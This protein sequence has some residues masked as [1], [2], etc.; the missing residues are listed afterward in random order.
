MFLDLNMKKLNYDIIET[1]VVHEKYVIVMKS[2]S[3]SGHVIGYTNIDAFCVEGELI[4]VISKFI[5]FLKDEDQG[6][7]EHSFDEKRFLEYTKILDPYTDGGYNAIYELH[8]VEYINKN[9]SRFIVSSPENI[10]NF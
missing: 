1:P 10:Y 5:E 8:R 7:F 9:G 6:Y 2:K 4:E 3:H